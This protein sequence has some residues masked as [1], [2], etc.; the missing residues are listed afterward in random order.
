LVT[1]LGGIGV[2]SVLRKNRAKP[3]PIWWSGGTKHDVHGDV[4]PWFDPK[5]DKILKV[6]TSPMANALFL[7]VPAECMGNKVLIQPDQRP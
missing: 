7:I 2:D 6:P 1:V 5:N 3:C 4:P